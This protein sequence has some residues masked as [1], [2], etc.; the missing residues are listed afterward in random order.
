MAKGG[1]TVWW[2]CDVARHRRAL[3]VDLIAVHGAVAVACDAVLCAHAAEQRDGGRVRDGYAAIA[4]DAGCTRD[5]VVAWVQ[6]AARM[7]WLDDL[8]V[9]EDGLRFRV[10]VSGWDQDQA[11]GVTGAGHAG[12]TVS[13]DGVAG[14]LVALLGDGLQHDARAVLEA[15]ADAG[16]GE[17]ALQRAA[18]SIGVIKRR[19]GSGRAHQ[20]TWTAPERLIKS[21]GIDNA[22]KP[23]NV[24]S[25]QLPTT[26]DNSRQD[27]V[28]SGVGSGPLPTT[29]DN[30]KPPV[31]R[32]PTL[33]TPYRLDESRVKKS[34]EGA[35][36]RAIPDFLHDL[37]ARLQAVPSW[38]GQLVQGADA[39]VLALVDSDPGAPW[40]ELAG[41]AVASRLDTS[42][43][44]L[45][46][47][48][49]VKALELRLRDH[50]SGR[51]GGRDPKAAET[52]ARHRRQEQALRELSGGALFA[53]RREAS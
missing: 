52:E 18:K 30:E 1:R 3:M 8:Q 40:M 37:L 43:G 6:D 33:P 38:S 14:W 10:R 15:G 35:Q 2:K 29:P 49:P 39:G 7:G 21:T 31:S 41:E 26:P 4:R 47:D 19:S 22:E 50:R 36:V 9:D 44:S 46:T 45:R 53:G 32:L 51:R 11:R 13:V 28:G 5:E 16:H 42:P 48:S 25:R 20:V 24:D 27:S 23:R 17:R 12:D 34:S